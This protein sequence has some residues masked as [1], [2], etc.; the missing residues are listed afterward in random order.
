MSGKS[1]IL[2]KSIGWFRQGKNIVETAR[3]YIGQG[4]SQQDIVE[5]A[6]D[7]Q[8]GSYTK[9]LE[10]PKMRSDKQAWGERIARILLELG[11]NSVC[12]AGVGEA[13][14]LAFVAKALEGRM[15]VSGFDISLSRLLHGRAFLARSGVGA[16]LFCA[17]ILQVP[18]PDSAVDVVLTNHSIEPNGG[19]EAPILQELLRVCARYLVMVE[20]DYERASRAQQ[21]R[22][23]KHNYVRN[24]RGHLEKLPG[25]LIRDEAWP[26]FSNPLNKASLFV[27]EKSGAAPAPP[28]FDFV[29]PVNKKP[30]TSVENFLFCPDE[31]LLYPV[32]F[33]IP[34]LRDASAIV[35]TQADR[36]R[37]MP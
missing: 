11:V 25:R 13:S 18:L 21:E 20:P 24:I 7:L 4:I 29:S 37:D 35:C 15:S 32:A 9:A 33:G 1:H 12:E 36:F 17:D 31:G 8:A 10:D 16:R 23:I 34:V 6:Y 22:M 19:A 14:T 30:L 27:F 26:I 28:Q 2:M 5:I 3:P